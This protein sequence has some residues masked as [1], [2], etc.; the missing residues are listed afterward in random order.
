MDEDK[1]DR[2]S[3]VQPWRQIAAILTRQ[4][5]AGTLTGALPGERQLAAEFGVSAA[6]LRKALDA[7]RRAGLI[8]TIPGWGSR[9]VPPG[10]R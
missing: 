10:E 5:E 7:L 9:V 1:I 6:S 8:E 3:G 2:A 4:I